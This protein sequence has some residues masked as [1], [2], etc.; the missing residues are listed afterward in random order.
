MPNKDLT[1]YNNLEINLAR[2]DKDS[3][4]KPTSM[5]I[6]LELPAFFGSTRELSRKLGASCTTYGCVD[7]IFGVYE[8][9]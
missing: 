5:E 9:G 3:S 2:L 6:V 8:C 4:M 1:K 7:V